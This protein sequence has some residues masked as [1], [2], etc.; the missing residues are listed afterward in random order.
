MPLLPS[1]LFASPTFLLFFPFPSLNIP[2]YGSSTQLMG[3]RYYPGYYPK[4]F[5]RNI[6]GFHFTLAT[7]VSAGENRARLRLNP[8][9]RGLRFCSQHRCSFTIWLSILTSKCGQM[10]LL[11]PTVPTVGKSTAYAQFWKGIGP[12]IHFLALPHPLEFKSR[13]ILL[14]SQAYAQKVRCPK[15]KILAETSALRMT[16][17]VSFR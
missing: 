2:G 15:R 8:V 6:C 12:Q 10:G 5:R 4:K 17:S 13:Q 11:R 16:V 9:S 3:S 7:F 1:P 14:D